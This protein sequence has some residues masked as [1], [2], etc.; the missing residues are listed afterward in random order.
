MPT[1]PRSSKRWAAV[2]GIGP[3]WPTSRRRQ[4]LPAA[5]RNDKT[6]RLTYGRNDPGEVDREENDKADAHH[7]GRRAAADRGSGPR[8][9]PAHPK[10]HRLVAE[11]RAADRH[12]DKRRSAGMAAPARRRRLDHGRSRRR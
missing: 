7:A 6:P 1:A 12:G 4:A 8:L 5:N 2:G 3:S 9:L 11:A 10:A